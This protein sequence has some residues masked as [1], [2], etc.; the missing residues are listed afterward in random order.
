[1]NEFFK[2]IFRVY[3]VNSEKSYE[4]KFAR[5]FQHIEIRW[6]DKNNRIF[7][8]S[9]KELYEKVFSINDLKYIK[10]FTWIFPFGLYWNLIKLLLKPI[11]KCF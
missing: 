6:T 11:K 2:S 4:I 8:N 3:I 5:D 7:N 1:M 10:I 9:K